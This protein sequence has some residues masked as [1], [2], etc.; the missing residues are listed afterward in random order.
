MWLDI[1]A[2]SIEGSWIIQGLLRR[3]L[4]EP[5]QVGSRLFCN[6]DMR[7]N[8]CVEASF[9][10]RQV[11]DCFSWSSW[12]C[13]SP[14]FQ[15][16]TASVDFPCSVG[17]LSFNVRKVMDCSSWHLGSV[18]ILS[19]NVRQVMDCFSLSSCRGVW[20]CHLSR[21]LQ[22]ILLGVWW[23]CHLSASDKSW[24]ASVHLIAECHLSASDKVMDCLSSSSWKCYP[25]T[26]DKSWIAPVGK[27][28]SGDSSLWSFFVYP[29]CTQAR[30]GW[31]QGSEDV[32]ARFLCLS[33]MIAMLSDSALTAAVFLELGRVSLLAATGDLLLVWVA[34]VW[35]LLLTNKAHR[36]ARG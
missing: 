30:L 25:S 32:D 13:G 15:R 10:V 27:S 26:W 14:I 24:T 23:E 35:A 17:V 1:F 31:C 3:I 2:T 9:N 22:L 11:M 16:Q 7:N 33:V 20:G 6:W 36:S 5:I 34:S 29:Q 8:R 28:D 12:E 4:F 21:L 18:G 19:F